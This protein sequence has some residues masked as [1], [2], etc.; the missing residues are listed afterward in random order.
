MKVAGRL[1]AIASNIAV[2]Y[3]LQNLGLTWVFESTV[4]QEIAD[5]SLVKVLE[6][7]AVEFDGAY[8]YYPSRKENLP[9]LKALIEWLKV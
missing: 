2:R 8:L 3:A 7:W 5:G 1:V 6:Q 4:A 9:A